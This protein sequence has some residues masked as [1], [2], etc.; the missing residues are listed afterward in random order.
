ME[1]AARGEW[2]VAKV[3]VVLGG[4]AA[5][6][7]EVANFDGRG[8][9]FRFPLFQF[10]CV[11]AAEPWHEP[12]DG[13][14]ISEAALIGRSCLVAPFACCLGSMRLFY[15]GHGVRFYAADRRF[16]CAASDP[17]CLAGNFAAA[18][19]DSPVVISLCSL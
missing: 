11:R 7:V 5:S 2:V 12:C 8:M 10:G 1:A 13:R 15:S 3:C 9:G 19:E 17:F 4:R 18:L 16:S 14:G 6:G